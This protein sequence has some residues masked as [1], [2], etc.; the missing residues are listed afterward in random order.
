MDKDRPLFGIALMLGF[1]ALAPLADALAKLLGPHMGV[2]QLVT[3]RFA[4]QAVIL[5]P[6]AIATRRPMRMD[7][8]IALL[9]T[10][11]TL[12]HIAGI[13]TVFVSLLYLP[14]AE[15]IAIA[16]VMPFILL[17]MGHYILGEEVGW[18]R[19][20]ACAVG[21][22]GTLLVIQPAFDT[23]GAPALLPLAVAFIFAAFMLVTRRIAAQTDPIGM[24]AVSALIA[25][26]I[27]VP[28]MAL[29]PGTPALAWTPPSPTGWTLIA[30][31]GA[32]GTLAHLL[33]TWSLRYAPAST[34]APMQY[35]EIPMA[36]LIGWALFSDLPGPLAALGIAITIASGLYVVMRER[37]SHRA[38]PPTP[39]SAPQAA[40]PAG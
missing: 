19:L 27:L 12:L 33:M 36:T 8:T 14:L 29:L 4:F 13:A 18:R 9:V 11:R 15:A 26:A 25:L 39:P 16:Y 22:V 24:Q 6:F 2:G 23:V 28:A 30:A 10:L 31:M 7:R 35:L 37:A 5:V 21:F 17:L 20:A 34:L 1:C 40:P 32:A 38:R 3:L